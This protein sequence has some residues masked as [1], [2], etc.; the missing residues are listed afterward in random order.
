[1]VNLAAGA[2]SYD[3]Y[4]TAPGAALG[5]ASATGISFGTA[6]GLIS[7]TPGSQLI[8]LTNAGTQ[9]VVFAIGGTTFTAGQNQVLV[10]A[11]PAAGS[12]VPRT[13]VVTAC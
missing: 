9:T 2:G 11:P 4:V 10:I 1:V 7:V 5:T 8:R 13:F 3:V 12:T 6:S